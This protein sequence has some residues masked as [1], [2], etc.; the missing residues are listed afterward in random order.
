MHHQH[1]RGM[2][3]EEWLLLL[4]LAL[5]WGG[6]FFF[7][8]ILVAHVPPFTV[9]LGRVGLAAIALNLLL[10]AKGTPL[11][12]DAALW[13]RLIVLG[14]LNNVIPFS[15]IAFG[16]TRI[17]SGLAAI[18][19]A[20]TPVFTIIVAHFMTHDEKLRWGKIVGIV[21]GFVGVSVLIGPA[22]FN[23][24]GQSS[25]LGDCAC[26][27]AALSYGF[28]G[29]YARRFRTMAPLQ[30]AT[31][32][33]TASTLIALPLSFLVDHPWRMSSLPVEVWAAFGGI[34]LLST[35]L[36]FILYFRL[37]AT[38]GATNLS[39]VT[40]LLPIMALGLG[41]LFLGETVRW[42]AIA[43]LL[44]IGGGLAAIDGRLWRA[45]RLRRTQSSPSV[46]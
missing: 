14:A 13:R 28:G 24:G 1:E 7:F 35:A 46:G 43:G 20:T 44:L 42:Y 34:A 10:L 22:L 26:L 36:A 17:S 11:P 5:L 30:L 18:L 39:L 23:N 45:W 37:L 41:S 3:V 15:A 33:L 9:V 6:S 31:G 25:V 2:G 27:G 40:F 16:E 8:K 38:A 29:V 19:N 12:L 21:M 4:V 32:Q